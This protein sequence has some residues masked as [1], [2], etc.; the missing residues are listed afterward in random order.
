MLDFRRSSVLLPRAEREEAIMQ[1]V[2]DE[3][4]ATADICTLPLFLLRVSC[5]C[6]NGDLI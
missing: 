5:V 3:G 2:G 1:E 4:D 6:D